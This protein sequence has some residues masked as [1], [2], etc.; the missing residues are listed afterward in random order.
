M[1]AQP[2]ISFMLFD[3]HSAV[4]VLFNTLALGFWPGPKVIL[5]LDI[6]KME[7][8]SFGKFLVG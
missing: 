3:V 7:L 2:V 4:P 8:S 6:Y 1:P 5:L